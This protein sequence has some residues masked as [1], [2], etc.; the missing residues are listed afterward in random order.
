MG[1]A[2]RKHPILALL[3]LAAALPA[4]TESFGVYSGLSQVNHQYL[5]DSLTSQEQAYGATFDM[6]AY[7]RTPTGWMARGLKARIQQSPNQLDLDLHMPLYQFHKHQGVWLQLQ[8]QQDSLST[9]LSDNRIYIDNAGNVQALTSGD[10]LLIERTFLRGQAYWYESVK[11]E[12]PINIVGLYY[13]V[14]TSPASATLSTTNAEVFDGRFSGFGFSLGRIK[15]DRGLNFQW[16]LNLAQLTT[17]FSNDA[18]NHQSASS[19]ESTVYHVDLNLDWHYRY[20]LSPYWYLVPS[21]H[22]QYQ[23]IFQTQLK[24]EY[25]EHEQL[26]FTQLSGFIALRRYF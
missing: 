26:S 21:I 5:N 1:M 14:E 22:V 23:N 2:L 13:S 25:L 17:S 9:L 11:D 3:I 8:W 24:P 20:Y 6:Q 15:D 10:T 19:Q 12:G 16:R 7:R 4:Y 18:T